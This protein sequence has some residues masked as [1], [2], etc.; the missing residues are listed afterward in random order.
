MSDVL[1]LPPPGSSKYRQRC[2]SSAA[3]QLAVSSSLP[4]F[5]NSSILWHVTAICRSVEWCETIGRNVI[6]SPGCMQEI[7]KMETQKNSSIALLLKHCSHRKITI[8]NSEPAV[9]HGCH[10]WKGHPCPLKSLWI[11]V[12]QEWVCGLVKGRVNLSHHKG[13]FSGRMTRTFYPV[14]EGTQRIRHR[15]CESSFVDDLPPS[16]DRG[17]LD[18]GRRS[19]KGNTQ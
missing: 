15:V 5:A 6:M 12:G 14:S 8:L 9:P 10:I 4:L 1:L 3:Y 11:L 18:P 17:A 13:D 2:A 7:N 19:I 16:S